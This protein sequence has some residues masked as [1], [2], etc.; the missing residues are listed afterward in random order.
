MREDNYKPWYYIDK[1]GEI[2]LECPNEYEYPH[3]FTEGLAGVQDKSSHKWGYINKR[4]ELVIPCVWRNVY[5]FKNGRAEVI[6]D[7]EKQHYI[8]KTGKVIK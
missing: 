3:S 7:N 6:D 4:G 2:V 5:D 1:T 8:D